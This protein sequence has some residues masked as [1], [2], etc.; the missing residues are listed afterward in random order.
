[1]ASHRTI[2]VASKTHARFHYLAEAEVLPIGQTSDDFPN[3]ATSDASSRASAAIADASETIPSRSTA[4]RSRS[5]AGTR[6]P[7]DART[8]QW[9]ADG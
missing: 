3:I 6:S 9:S 2:P 1:M 8:R 4:T 7:M 5:G